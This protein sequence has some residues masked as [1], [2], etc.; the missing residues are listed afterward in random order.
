MS[1]SS[2]SFLEENNENK[3]AKTIKPTKKIK[4]SDFLEEKKNELGIKDVK[5]QNTAKTNKNLEE[6]EVNKIVSDFM[7]LEKQFLAKLTPSNKDS[8][9]KTSSSERQ[10]VQHHSSEEL[11]DLEKE[12]LKKILDALEDEESREE[13]N[14][15][16]NQQT[17]FEL[18]KDLEKEKKVHV[19]DNEKIE[20]IEL[21][22]IIESIEQE[23]LLQDRLFTEEKKKQET[24]A[25]I[26][27]IEENEEYDLIPDANDIS[28]KFSQDSL[29]TNTIIDKQIEAIQSQIKQLRESGVNY[30]YIDEKGK[31]TL[32]KYNS[33]SD[34]LNPID[35]NE[36]NI[37]A[38]RYYQ[39]MMLILKNLSHDST[40][41]A[42]KQTIDKAFFN[43]QTKDKDAKFVVVKTNNT[44]DLIATFE[45]ILHE[46]MRIQKDKTHKNLL[47][48]R[49]LGVMLEDHPNLLTISKY[50]NNLTLEKSEN[51]HLSEE[52]YDQE[53]R[54]LHHRKWFTQACEKAGLSNPGSWLENFFTGPDNLAR[55]KEMGVSAPPSAR[56]LPLPANSQDITISKCSMNENGLLVEDQIKIS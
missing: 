13:E 10:S 48:A 39:G 22:K 17:S 29:E 11:T 50:G 56:W 52:L 1:S 47:Y 8:K 24:V 20:E 27:E 35:P 45:E 41:A 49:D 23:E 30:T 55:L 26:Q 37:Q 36:A 33:D 34:I 53:F 38:L 31:T 7:N 32:V 14:K 15:L 6:E 12:K 44:L 43:Y 51:T 2:H 46:K 9:E 18:N 42:I 28:E 16:L 5:R 19:M 40:K 25:Q 4:M 54:H 3:S 21:K